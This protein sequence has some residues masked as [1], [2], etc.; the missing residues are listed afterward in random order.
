MAV[1]T[2]DFRS[3][4]FRQVGGKRG[5]I[6]HPL[7]G[8]SVRIVDPESLAPL[9]LGQP[10][11]LLVRGPNIMQGYLGQAEKTAQ[12]LREGWYITGDI[13]AVVLHRCEHAIGGREVRMDSNELA[14]G[15]H[16]SG[17]SLPELGQRPIELVRG[18]DQHFRIILNSRPMRRFGPFIIKDELAHAVEL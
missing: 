18:A 16:G 3:A 13:A 17:R 15:H 4:G 5:K 14:D 1:N 11:L 10:G 12:V 6:G 8:M 9:P 7:P 2:Y